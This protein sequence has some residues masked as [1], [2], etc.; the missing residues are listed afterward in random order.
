MYSGEIQ[1]KL[2]RW[3]QYFEELLNQEEKRFQ[4]VI[5]ENGRGGRHGRTYRTR[6]KRSHKITNKQ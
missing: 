2:N 6:N 3:V 5:S 4:P 1:R